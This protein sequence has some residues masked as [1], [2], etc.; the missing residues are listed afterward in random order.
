[1]VFFR[2]GLV[3]AL[4][5]CAGSGP[6]QAVAQ[7]QIPPLHGTTLTGEKVDLPKCLKGRVGVLVLGFSQASRDAVAEWGKRLT[8]EYR[9]SATVVYYEM[10]V[11]ESVPHLLRGFVLKQI[12]KSVPEPGRSRFIPILDHEA[13]WKKAS[14]FVK[15]DDAYVLVVDAEGDV[16]WKTE[17]GATDAAV[18]EVLRRVDGLRG[19]STRASQ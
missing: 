11:L 10:P 12:Q 16:A 1:M 4:V 8:G 14:G 9:T 13:D 5:V 19:T 6:T 2:T 15:P 18:A 3:L 7:T 17:G